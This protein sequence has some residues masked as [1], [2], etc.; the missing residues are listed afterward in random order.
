MPRK[1]R[2]RPI[3]PGMTQEDIDRIA[4]YAGRCLTGFDDE[5]LSG[6][7]IVCWDRAR[8]A[9]KIS[10][11]WKVWKGRRA[12][13]IALR[14]ELG[15]FWVSGAYRTPPEFKYRKDLLIEWDLGFKSTCIL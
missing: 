2:Y 4:N 6:L 8:R 14:K 10:Q 11:Y 12:R 13:L 3:P 1:P 9:R 7:P 5:F 15:K